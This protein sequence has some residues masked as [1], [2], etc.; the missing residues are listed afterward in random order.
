MYVCMYVFNGRRAC[1]RE[2]RHASIAPVWFVCVCVCVCVSVCMY[3]CIEWSL[4]MPLGDTSRIEYS[5]AV[6]VCVCVYLS[7]CI[8][9]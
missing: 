1:L 5:C 4:R 3:V 7:M 6:C 9:V 2:T 8:C